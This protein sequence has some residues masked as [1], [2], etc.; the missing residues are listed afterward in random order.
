VDEPTERDSLTRGFLFADLRGYTE[1]VER[2]GG[3]AAS[4]LLD[5]Y[6]ELVRRQVA[7]FRGA[8]IKTEGDSFYVVFPSVSAAVRAGL[9]IIEDAAGANATAPDHPI[10]VGIGVHAGE[11]VETAEGYVGSPVNI[12]ARLCSHARAGEL[13]VSDTVRALTSTVVRAGFTARGRQRFKGIAEPIQIFAVSGS[14]ST[15]AHRA[16]P[17]LTSRWP[18]L[19]AV[20]AFAVITVAAAFAFGNRGQ[21]SV[22]PSATPGPST[23]VASTPPTSDPS[24]YTSRERDLL[25]LIPTDMAGD[26]RAAPGEAADTASVTF[27]CDL[28]LGSGADTVWWDRFGSKG[29]TIVAFERIVRAHQLPEVACGSDIAE[30]Q[31]EWRLGSTFS[32]SR[33]CWSAED[34]AWVAWSYLDEQVLARAVR[35]DADSRRLDA[36]WNEVAPFV[37]TR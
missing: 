2:H 12:A 6:R 8:E 24:G 32:G 23:G 10:R 16:R 4:R 17:R 31:G 9:A 13:L 26:C 28:P 19:A 34:G 36:W 30:G 14:A 15:V 37:N 22:A 21:G 18:A 7:G 11:T 35:A 25:A 3:E 5:R 1:Y 29:D 33:A 20:A 27:R